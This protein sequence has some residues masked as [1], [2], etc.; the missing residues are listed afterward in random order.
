MKTYFTTFLYIE[1]VIRDNEKFPGTFRSDVSTYYVTI[2]FYKF[3]LLFLKKSENNP[4][5]SGGGKM[6]KIFSYTDNLGYN[7]L[8]KHLE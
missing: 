3:F 6:Y 8:K 2:A 4:L 1:N 5:R 7:K